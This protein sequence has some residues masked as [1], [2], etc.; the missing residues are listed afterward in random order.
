[1]VLT[2]SVGLSMTEAQYVQDV[3]KINIL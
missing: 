3:G 1:M 2:L